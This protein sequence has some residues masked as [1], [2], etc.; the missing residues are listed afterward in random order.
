LPSTS[1]GPTPNVKLFPQSISVSPVNE[2][3]PLI[4]SS[5]TRS[6]GLESFQND[7]RH[8]L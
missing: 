8:P 7:I 4:T 5:L 1:L 3:N 2:Q 6:T